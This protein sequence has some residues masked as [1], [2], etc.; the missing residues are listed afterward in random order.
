M[1]W[2]S[3]VLVLW[4]IWS[5]LSCTLLVGGFMA[6]FVPRVGFLAVPVRQSKSRGKGRLKSWTLC[7]R[8]SEVRAGEVDLT[9]WLG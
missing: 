6:M 9:A 3:L 1:A 2:A 5:Y 4:A 7:D 8:L